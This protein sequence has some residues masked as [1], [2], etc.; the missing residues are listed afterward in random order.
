MISN[1]KNLRPI[2]IKDI[3]KV[4]LSNNLVKLALSR[5][6]D[7]PDSVNL[8][9][10]LLAAVAHKAAEKVNQETNFSSAASEILNNGALVQVYTKA[11]Q[12]KE[13]WTL[14]E[15]TTVYPGKS[16]KGVYFSAGKTYY[17]T[18]IKGNFTFKIDK[19]SGVSKDDSSKAAKQMAKDEDDFLDVA[20]DISMGRKSSTKDKPT[21]GDVGRKRRK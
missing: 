16:I 18:G 6:T 15:F 19:G 7:N 4:K 21:V 10:H 9:Y 13:N 17:S 20:K 3:G 1:L 11:R 2:N 8:Y 14:D 5:D 12:G